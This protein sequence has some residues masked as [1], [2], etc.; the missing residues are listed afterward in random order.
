MNKPIN[1]FQ[2]NELT[3][4]TNYERKILI[5]SAANILYFVGCQLPKL[6]TDKA[7]LNDVQRAQ[8][9]LDKITALVKSKP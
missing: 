4:L 2:F 5:D 7:I 6:H 1:Q 8:Q 9:A 3:E